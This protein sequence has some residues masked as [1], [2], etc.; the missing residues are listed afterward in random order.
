M[1]LFNPILAAFLTTVA[2][3]SFSAAAEITKDSLEMVKKNVSAKKAVLVDVR[4]KSEWDEGHIEGSV[5]LPLSALKKGVTKEQLAKILPEDRVLYTFC[6]VG[7]R[8]VTAGNMLEEHGY[9]VRALK[10]GYK[11]LV[12]AGFKKA[13]DK[14]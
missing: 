6:V 7:K 9:E 4:E 5:F 14:S 13:K 2:S 3:G 10:P 11:E 8:A 12:K 1:R